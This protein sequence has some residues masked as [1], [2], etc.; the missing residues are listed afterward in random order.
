MLNRKNFFQLF[1]P[2]QIMVLFLRNLYAVIAIR[3]ESKIIL[4]RL[5]NNILQLSISAII[6]LDPGTTIKHVYPQCYQNVL[7][8]YFGI[9]NIYMQSVITYNTF[10]LYIFYLAKEHRRG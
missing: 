2:T 1:G 10:D 8:A 3:A 6:E 5:V 7:I 9:L 4:L